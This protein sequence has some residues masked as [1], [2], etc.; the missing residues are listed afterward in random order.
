M[1]RVDSPSLTI[2]RGEVSDALLEQCL[3]SFKSQ[4]GL[5]K[6]IMLRDEQDGRIINKHAVNTVTELLKTIG[7]RVNYLGRSVA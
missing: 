4:L 2:V 1:H 5:I 3:A 7:E 6:T